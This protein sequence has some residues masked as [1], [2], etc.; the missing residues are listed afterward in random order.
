MHHQ[1]TPVAV[2]SCG[3]AIGA[4]ARYAVGLEWPTAAGHFPTSTLLI[5]V[6]G[7]AVMGIFM[8]LITEKWSVHPLMRPFFG[9]GVLGGFTTFSTYEVEAQHLLQHG[10]A[11]IAV[12]YLVITLLAAILAVWVAAGL[13][14]V[15]V[16][17]SEG[18]PL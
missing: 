6:I 14:R 10:H 16:L 18:R 17:R 4:V 11:L 7:C 1:A 2:I 3:G 9:T 12:A 5:N 13:T 8:V 15:A